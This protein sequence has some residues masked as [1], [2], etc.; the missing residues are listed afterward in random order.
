MSGAGWG[1]A[2][3]VPTI[4]QI[5][6]R[7]GGRAVF[8]I[9]AKDGTP[10]VAPLAALI[11]KYNLEDSVFINTSEV[12]VAQAITNAGIASHVYNVT[13]TTKLNACV[14]AGVDLIEV[15]NPTN[16]AFVTQAL[17]SGFPRLI[18]G[19][20]YRR[21]VLA[22]HDPRLHGYVN[23]AIGYLD[24]K[25]KYTSSIAASAQSQKVS[26]GWFSAALLW[27][28]KPDD[29]RH[30]HQRRAE[31]QSGPAGIPRGPVRRARGSDAGHVLNHRYGEGVVRC[32]GGH[33][34]PLRHQGRLPEGQSLLERFG[35]QRRRRLHLRRA[36]KRAAEHLA[37][38]HRRHDNDPGHWGEYRR[39]EQR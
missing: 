25:T 32:D 8:T 16:T 33:A 37:G 11:K 14:A 22:S 3:R 13:D 4:E 29:G 9:E 36:V 24:K 21:D 10:S 6:T 12:T 38:Q 5:F 34:G 23:E 17:T 20:T 35:C 27:G 19:P 7:L 31:A 1:D 18:A 2:D 15:W 28:G 26:S 39:P 30:A